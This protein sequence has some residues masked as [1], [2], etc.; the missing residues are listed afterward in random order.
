MHTPQKP[1]SRAVLA[2]VLLSITLAGCK[3]LM[4]EPP[5][6]YVVFFEAKDAALNEDGLRIVKDAAVKARLSHPKMVQIAVPTTQV[7]PG[8]DT[9]LSEPRY[10]AVARALIDAG[11]DETII[12]RASL[13]TDDAKTDASGARRVE[14]RLVG[15]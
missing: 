15:D 7:A 8:Y 3:L 11:V 10:A 4:P 13:T 1:L 6:V 14:I 12:A 2:A 9:S 5:P